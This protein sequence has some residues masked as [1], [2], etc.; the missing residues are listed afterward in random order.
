MAV[1]G[2]PVKS[3]LAVP[4]P[5]RSLSSFFS[6][7][8][9][10]SLPLGLFPHLYSR[11]KTCISICKYIHA[12]VIDICTLACLKIVWNISAASQQTLR[13]LKYYKVFCLD[14]SLSW[15]SDE[16]IQH[17]QYI[18]IQ[19]TFNFTIYPKSRVPVCYPLLLNG[20]VDRLGD[21]NTIWH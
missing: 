20:L 7:P 13:Q 5:A 18:Y 4:V 14:H 3:R 11:I 15:S 19:Q 6:W 1:N 9:S 2:H 16:C 8:S 10:A 21:E 17:I 12:Q